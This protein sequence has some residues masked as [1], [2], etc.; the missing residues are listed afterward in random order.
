MMALIARE[1]FKALA[2][3]QAI[4]YRLGE[5]LLALDKG[6]SDVLIASLNGRQVRLH[7]RDVAPGAFLL[8]LC[9]EHINGS[10]D[11]T[12]TVNVTQ[13]RH[14]LLLDLTSLLYRLDALLC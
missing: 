6:K 4:P 9:G 11:V 13:L 1:L 14:L 2:L 12:E 5:L 7:M 3:L 10:A 8:E